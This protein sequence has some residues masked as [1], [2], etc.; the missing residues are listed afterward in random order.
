MQIYADLR[1][2]SRWTN[3]IWF[4]LNTFVN[5]LI[6]KVKKILR[7]L[8]N[9]PYFN[10]V[11]NITALLDEDQKK[12]SVIMLF[13]LVLNAVFDVIGLA[14]I[15][16]LI[17]AALAPELIQEKWYLNKIYIFLGIK[18]TIPFL[19][20]LSVI[21]FIVFIIKNSISLYILYIQARFSFNI[22]LRLSIK[23]FQ[24]YYQNG[25]LYIQDKDVGK[26]QYDIYQLPYQFA[27]RYMI[28]TFIFTTELVVLLIILSAVVYYH[29]QAF[30]I[31]LIVIVPVFIAIYSFS[32]KSIT[33]IGFQRNFYF[34][35]ITTAI[36][37]SMVAYPD[38]KLSNKEKNALDNYRKLQHKVNML[39]ALN[40]GL[41]GKI[42]TKTNDVVFGL[43]IMLI[44]LAALFFNNNSEN[45]LSLLS[46]F[47]IAG[48]RFL[49]SINKMMGATL[50]MKNLSYLKEEFREIREV[51]IQEYTSVKRLRLKES[52]EF[53]KISYH[54]P[55]NE[56]NVLDKFSLSVKKGETLGII[57]GSGSG[58]TTLLNILLRLLNETE[59]HIKVDGQQL[60]GEENARFQKSIGF[61]QQQVFIKNGTLT[62]NI[63]FGEEEPDLEKVSDSI[64]KA[65][66]KEF[67]HGHPEGKDMKLGENGVKLSGGQRQ[68][69]GIAR[70]LYK[71]SDILIFDEATSA[72][73]M[74]T[75]DAIK[76]TINS[77]TKLDKTIFIVAHR[78]TTLNSCD[79]I[80]E[81]ENGRIKREMTYEELFDNKIL[82]SNG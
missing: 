46:V 72:L 29:P 38:I 56:S 4:F 26:K 77:L 53:E 27:G 67:V 25:Y 68:R 57:G 32:K 81:L 52:I 43:G 50:I 11:R 76:E 3:Y 31:L 9:N 45:I 34:P 28:Q 55:L 82:G 5:I 6:I 47:A 13:L 48:Y 20:A 37:E 60:I 30:F 14:A 62:E 71:Q 39:D 22:S 19:F 23:Q 16:P 2:T 79:R 44:F 18:D 65:M 42:P 54:Y 70:A 12:R 64:E 10:A 15:W 40:L 75:E 59:G 73:D 41:F 7:S 69:V 51:Q 61:V 49:P 80:I 66:L 17:D 21:V 33:K 8:S 24:K 74:E 58:K 78:I 35:K 63:A 1:E 36:S